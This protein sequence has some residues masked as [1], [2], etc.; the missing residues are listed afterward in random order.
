MKIKE[1]GKKEEISFNVTCLLCYYVNVQILS[2][3]SVYLFLKKS[4]HQKKKKF[5]TMSMIKFVRMLPTIHVLILLKRFV[6][7]L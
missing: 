1:N 2:T 6:T 5:V 4:V 3:T 7:L